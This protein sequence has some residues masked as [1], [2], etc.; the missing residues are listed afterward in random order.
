MK[1][2][3]DRQIQALCEFIYTLSPEVRVE[4]DEAIYEDEHANLQVIPPLSWDED[5]CLE[6]QHKIAERATDIHMD[7]GYF[8][9]V[10]VYTPEE[11][12]FLAQRELEQ[13]RQKQHRAEKVLSEAQELGLYR[14]TGVD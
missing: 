10:Y 11:Q 12:I 7:T 13:A 14:P 3:L 8:I 2:E 5:R 1:D 9:L 6:F 4:R